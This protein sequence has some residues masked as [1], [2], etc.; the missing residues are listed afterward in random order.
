[1]EGDDEEAS[2][3][4]TTIFIPTFNS[5]LDILYGVLFL[6]CFLAGLLGNF[7]CFF[8]F[9]SRKRDV[10]NWIYQLITVNDIVICV[11]VL[12]V[13]LAYLNHRSPGLLFVTKW[14]CV[15]WTYIW[16]SNC[17]LSV[18]LVV[19]LCSSRT[20]SLLR[21]FYPQKTGLVL[22]VVLVYFIFT[23]LQLVGIHLQPGFTLGYDA[24]F[25]TC[26][27]V[28]DYDLFNTSDDTNMVWI[29]LEIGMIV[30]F[31][32]PLVVVTISSTISTYL[33][34]R[35]MISNMECSS[36]S[37]R[38]L[39]D[40]RRKA[41]ITIL[42]FSLVYGFFNLPLVILFVVQ[43]IESRSG[44]LFKDAIFHFDMRDPEY[45]YYTFNYIYTLSTALNSAINPILYLWR[46]PD[47]RTTILKCIKT[48]LRKTPDPTTS[49]YLSR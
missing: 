49:V 29:L 8:F 21:P 32:L 27:V 18:F 13:G 35:Q 2:S 36:A 12:P 39:V 44:Q 42:I 38:R 3:S 15:S 23:L 11:S 20:W 17:R 30:T 33:L 10:S 47:C 9:R 14:T 41:S 45:Y 4:T 22:G 7:S 48:L 43:A 34:N 28:V 25:G 37:S 5:S 40:S 19:V 1:M 31:C 6:V 26:S 46:M 16:N 24:D